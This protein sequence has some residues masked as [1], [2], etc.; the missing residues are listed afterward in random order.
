MTSDTAPRS[1][2]R[3]HRTREA[4][5]ASIGQIRARQASA[6]RLRRLVGH[7]RTAR[8]AIEAMA[9]APVEAERALTELRYVMTA[10]EQAIEDVRGRAASRR[11]G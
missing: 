7:G 5:A 2:G 11:G 3:A 6:A 1:G 10:L 9:A 4:I 8:Q